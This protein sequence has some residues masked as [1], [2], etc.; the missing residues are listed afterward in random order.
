MYFYF[1]EKNTER[2]PG[3]CYLQVTKIILCT[4]SRKY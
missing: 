3:K 4:L 2:V 1:T